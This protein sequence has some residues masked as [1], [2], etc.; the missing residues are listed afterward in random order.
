M[1]EE[2]K[3]PRK[4]NP[5]SIL[6]ILKPNADQTGLET[7]RD[8]IEEEALPDI[9]KELASGT[10]VLRRYY[11]RPLLKAEIKRDRVTIG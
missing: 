1:N 8:G 9:I 3:K 10:Y 4:P 11:D 7:V 2:I 6:C 5:K